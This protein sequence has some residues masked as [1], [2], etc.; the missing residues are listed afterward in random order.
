MKL[1]DQSQD[2]VY[3]EKYEAVLQELEELKNR[4]VANEA[5]QQNN[6]TATSN[7]ETQLHRAKSHNK[8]LE[9]KLRMLV[10]EMSEKEK[11]YQKKL[12][13]QHQMMQEQYSKTEHLLAQKDSE[14]QN[15]IVALEQQLLRQRERSLTVI[16]EKDKEIQMLKSSFDALLPKKSIMLDGGA[17]KFNLPSAR[18]GSVKSEANDLVS[19][20]ITIENNPPMLYYT[21][22]LARKEVQISGLRKQNV[23]LE[24]SLRD[25]E[26]NSFRIAEKHEEDVKKLE[27]QIK[28][29]ALLSVIEKK[30]N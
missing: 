1:C 12:E 7:N 29:Y 27:T 22:E 30:K 8:N 20:L 3:K 15:K 14:Y 24:T 2:F 17:Q 26:R 23:Q 18:H 28:R 9:E 6:E 5:H 25:L 11:E 21:Q 10:S 16:Q 19:G 13:K 4:P